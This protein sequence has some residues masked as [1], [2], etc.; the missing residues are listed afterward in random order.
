LELLKDEKIQQDY[1]IQ[2]KKYVENIED[3]DIVVE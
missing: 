3:G 2:M 1:T